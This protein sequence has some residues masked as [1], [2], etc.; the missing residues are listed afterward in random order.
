MV[1]SIP[2]IGCAKYSKSARFAASSRITASSITPKR[3][4]SWVVDGELTP[5]MVPVNP[6]LR[7][8]RA[9][10]P[11]IRPTPTMATVFTGLYSA[12]DGRSKDAKLLHQVHELLRPQGLVSAT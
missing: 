3:K 10:E 12:A 9:K 4:A 6:A 11:P 1:L 2:W 5:S 8:A 7:S